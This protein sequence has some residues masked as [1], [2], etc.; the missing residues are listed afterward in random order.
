MEEADKNSEESELAEKKSI[1]MKTVECDQAIQRIFTNRSTAQLGNVAVV[2]PM[3][4]QIYNVYQ[5]AH[6]HIDTNKVWDLNYRFDKELKHL[7]DIL[8]VEFEVMVR[9]FAAST[10]TGWIIVGDPANKQVVSKIQVTDPKTGQPDIVDLLKMPNFDEGIL[11][12][13]H[14]SG[15]LYYTASGL[16]Q[17]QDVDE[18][19]ERVKAMLRQQIQKHEQQLA[20]AAKAQ[21]QLKN[22]YAT[23]LIKCRLELQARECV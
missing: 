20:G 2:S 17:V 19:N 11:S 10:A 21:R 9:F 15:S 4:L 16:T 5:D 23:L 13:S 12:F 22:H 3:R 6:G 1:I 14:K 18:S 7:G 8:A